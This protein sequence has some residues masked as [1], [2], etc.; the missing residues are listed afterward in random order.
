MDNGYTR[1]EMKI[2]W[3]TRRIMGDD[4]I[5]VNPTT[6]RI[7]VFYGHSEAVHIETRDRLSAD[8]AREIL[9]AAPGVVVMDERAD[10]GYPTAATESAGVDGVFVGR[11]REDISCPRGL[12]MWV[13]PTTCAWELRSTASRSPKSW[14]V[15]FF[16][17]SEFQYVPT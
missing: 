3:E 11:I 16:R 13:V 17:R 2:V 8:E 15:S 6:V 10:G 1:E 5:R 14:Q 7:P 4:S 9:S 12:D